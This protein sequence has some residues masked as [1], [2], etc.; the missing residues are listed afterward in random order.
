M[1]SLEQLAA[2]DSLQWLRTGSRAA[3][4]KHCNQSTI[5]RSAKRCEE[6]FKVS[7]AKIQSEWVLRGD[8]SLLLAERK[9]HQRYRWD[10]GLDLRLDAQHWLRDFYA[11]LQL[12][13][14][15]W[16]NLNFLEYERPTYLL[17]NRIIDA[18]LCSAP[19]A[20]TDSSLHCVQ[21]STMPTYLCV[22]RYHPLAKLGPRVTLD[23]V[24][25]YPL[26]PLPPKA[27]PVFSQ[28]IRKLGL[29]Y[30]NA[31]NR[32][33]QAPDFEDLMVGI[34]NPVTAALYGSQSIILP[35][36][37]PISVGDVLVVHIDYSA[38]P[39]LRLLIESLINH[40]RLA[41]TDRPDIKIAEAIHT[42]I[43]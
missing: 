11:G 31:S 21:L 10:Q 38:H 33:N 39:R 23:D 22:N 15:V 8:E 20:P 34:A 29:D 1:I 2:L 14:W 17:K 24:R 19:D 12:E 37:I 16:G 40:L 7:L 6:I 32:A 27:F 41:A 18:W 28:K 35:I 26:L 30:Q 5:S 13:G 3:E 36:N 43:T 4:L 42:Q 9:V 25:Q